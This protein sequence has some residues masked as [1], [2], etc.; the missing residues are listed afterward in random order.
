[1]LSQSLAVSG[2]LYLSATYNQAVRQQQFS[3]RCTAGWLWT[4][5]D[6]HCGTT[7]TLSTGSIAAVASSSAVPDMTKVVAYL[8]DIGLTDVTAKGLLSSGDLPKDLS[9]TH[10]RV[11]SALAYLHL[12]QTSTHRLN[13]PTK[14]DHINIVPETLVVYVNVLSELRD[15]IDVLCVKAALVFIIRQVIVKFNSSIKPNTNI[16]KAIFTADIEETLYHRLEILLR[17]KN[18]HFPDV[19]SEVKQ[20]VVWCIQGYVSTSEASDAGTHSRPAAEEWAS[21]VTKACRD[22]LSPTHPILALFYTRIYKLMMRGLCGQSYTSKLVGYSLHSK[23]QTASIHRYVA[24][25]VMHPFFV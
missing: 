23:S 21:E 13:T 15:E 3:L 2:L 24:V 1:M 25:A 22:I 8:N 10:S 18:V 6:T 17:D 9:Y 4:C 5:L 14:A 20:C 16:K 19:V 7:T 12:L 11:F